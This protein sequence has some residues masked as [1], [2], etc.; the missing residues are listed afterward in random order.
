MLHCLQPIW[1]HDVQN[2]NDQAQNHASKHDKEEDRSSHPGW[3]RPCVQLLE[4]VSIGGKQRPEEKG[5]ELDATRQEG[6]P[7]HAGI[8][9]IL[10]RRLID[11]P[12]VC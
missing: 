2:R 4:R 9:A 1:I 11:V 5:A 10:K 6:Q 8:V 12:D 3:G 7:P